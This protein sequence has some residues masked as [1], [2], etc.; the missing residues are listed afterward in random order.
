MNFRPC[1]VVPAYNPGPALDRTLEA[2]LATG[3]PVFLQDDGSDGAT[4]ARLARLQAHPHLRLARWEEN[5]GKGRAVCALLRRAHEAGFTHALQIDADG[6]HDPEAIPRFL[7]LGEA[8]PDAVIAGVPCYDRS[9]PP[10]RRYG[11]FVTH[12]WV[13]L[14]TLSTAIGD[15]LCGFRL[16]P[17]AP[18]VALLDR[19]R[20][21]ARM[22]FDTAIIVRLH[23]EGLPVL[24]APVRVTYPEDGVSHFRLFRDNLRLARLHTG[25][26]CG[27]LLRLPRLLARKFRRRKDDK[28]WYKTQERG[29]ALG[30]RAALW[31]Y[32]LGG[33]RSLRLLAEFLALYF[34]ATG[35]EA[36]RASGDYLARLFE[37]CGPL[38]GLPAR[39]GWRQRYRHI[40]TYTLSQV[41][42]F[43]GWIDATDAQ[44]HF[45]EEE[46]FHALR[47][48]GKGVLFLSA[49]MG[50]LDMLRGLASAKGF[51]GLNALVY[52]EHVVR[53]QALLKAINPKYEAHLIHVKEDGP[54]TVIALA[55]RI[56]KGECLFVKA[57]RPPVGAQARRM[58]VPF[59]GREAQFPV[60]PFFLAHLLRCP[61][62]L[63]FCLKDGDRHVVHMEPFAD[64]IDLPRTGRDAAL[65][66]WIERFAGAVEARC[67]QHPY[68]W[69]NFYDF[70]GGKPE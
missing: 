57:D 30:L 51:D 49:H 42:R 54:A 2:L 22:D 9:V 1:L 64:L 6:Q 13:W 62:Y 21:P 63:F 46:A 4:Q 45:P 33:A 26:V 41:D 25:L 48:S 58:A 20:L 52:S 23:W 35:T 39:P 12:A 34:F 40:R 18:T 19:V 32:R 3:L 67:R 28:D 36:R 16:Y 14:E 43:L 60:G 47:G 17:L 44:L 69:F 27:M 65:R 70:W 55:D 7:A 66:G 31:I 61:V 29:S 50:N 59:L 53:F 10:A 5:Q 15:S 8:H 56:A 37:A 38:P 24:N 11:R 68:E